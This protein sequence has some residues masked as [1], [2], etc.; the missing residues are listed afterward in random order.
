[1]ICNNYSPY[2]DASRRG[3][4]LALFSDPEEKKWKKEVFVNKKRHLVGTLFTISNLPEIFSRAFLRF[5]CK[6]SMKIIFYLPVNTDKP[7]VVA[8]LVFVCT[9]ASFIAQISSS[10]NVLKRDAILAPVAKQ[11]IAKDIPSYGS[12]SKRAK[13]AIQWFG[14]Y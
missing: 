1:M 12:Q 13:I 2:L 9:T 10:E 7:K 5:C 11:W 6:F 14:N 3:I 8:F 4:Y